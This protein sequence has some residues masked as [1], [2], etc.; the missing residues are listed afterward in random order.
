MTGPFLLCVGVARAAIP[1]LEAEANEF[2]ADMTE[3]QDG[4]R[5]PTA[6]L[7]AEKS[8]FL[9]KGDRPEPGVPPEDEDLPF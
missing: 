2:L 3:G 9:E 8:L 1:E 6:E 4:Q 7:V 5:K